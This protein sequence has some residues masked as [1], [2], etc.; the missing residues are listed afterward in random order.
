MKGLN[1]L[2]LKA[3]L[4]SEPW[5]D[6][7]CS[8]L[9]AFD[10]LDCRCH[11]LDGEGERVRLLPSS[12]GLN[13]LPRLTGLADSLYL[14]RTRLSGERLFNGERFGLDEEGRERDSDRDLDRDLERE[15]V[16]DIV[17]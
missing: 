16:E 9:P 2:S 7:A 11:D 6:P 3:S 17:E 13:R 5:P 1:D 8:G 12:V 10:A 15:R 4:E 14:R